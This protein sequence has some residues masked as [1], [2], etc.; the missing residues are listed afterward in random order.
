MK[1]RTE[2]MR[3]LREVIHEARVLATC[4]S[5]NLSAETLEEGAPKRLREK[6]GQLLG[7]GDVL[8]SEVAAVKI[9]PDEVMTDV[10]MLH[11]LEVVTRVEGGTN[12]A[13]DILK[14]AGGRLLET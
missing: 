12:S 2:T 5:K 6:I 4:R 8:E 11:P 14:H 10:N 7:G 13:L 1:E 3:K 9:V